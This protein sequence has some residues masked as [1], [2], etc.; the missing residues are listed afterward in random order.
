[1]KWWYSYFQLWAQPPAGKLL[2]RAREAETKVGGATAKQ[3]P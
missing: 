2:G 1:M 3:E